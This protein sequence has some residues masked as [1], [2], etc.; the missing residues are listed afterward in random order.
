MLENKQISEAGEKC[1]VRE[2][3]GS[4]VV[5]KK[6]E[7]GGLPWHHSL[8]MEKGYECCFCGKS[9][10]E[11]GYD[12]VSLTVT[13][14][15]DHLRGSSQHLWCHGYCLKKHFRKGIPTLMDAADA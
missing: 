3:F 9:I 5:W 10:E 13:L 2:G 1:Q 14:G 8:T 4:A 7:S 11:S 15:N 6:W 12:P